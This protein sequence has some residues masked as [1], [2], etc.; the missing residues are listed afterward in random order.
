MDYDPSTVSYEDL[1]KVFWNDSTPYARSWSR[2]YMSAIFYHSEEQKNL[3]IAMRDGEAAKRGRKVY[4]EIRPAGKFHRAEDYHQKYYLRTKSR[5]VEEIGALFA[6]D[7]GL[8]DS[9]IAAR[10]NG[11]FAGYGS[12]EDLRK[13]LKASGVPEEQIEKIRA[14]L[15]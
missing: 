1:L 14:L 13:E 6:S 11:Y 10:L 7:G 2:Q 15:R 4:T 5:A 8:V 9:Q 3:A 12:A